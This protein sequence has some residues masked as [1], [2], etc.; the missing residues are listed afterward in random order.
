[1]ITLRA[2]RLGGRPRVRP[3]VRVPAMFSEHTSSGILAF[4]GTLNLVKTRVR[5]PSC[6]GAFSSQSMVR[7]LR[8][9]RLHALYQPHRV[10]HVRRW[11]ARFTRAFA[12]ADDLIVLPLDDRD[13]A[14]EA[15]VP[16]DWY[17]NEGLE[18]ELA[19]DVDD[20]VVRVARRARPGDVVC[21]LGVPEHMAGLARHLL[22]LLGHSEAR[23]VRTT[24]VLSERSS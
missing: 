2:V 24:S 6:F 12:V 18:A 14:G 8:P 16:P 19:T 22:D 5:R 17:H 21:V 4:T 10:A 13:F 15:A 23:Q 11:R 9:R 3:V 7:K 1:M 20:A